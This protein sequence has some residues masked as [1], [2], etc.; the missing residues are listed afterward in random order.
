MMA[1]KMKTVTTDVV[2]L[3]GAE[4][5][6]RGLGAAVA[7]TVTGAATASTTGRL[8]PEAA[9]VPDLIVFVVVV[10]LAAVMDPAEAVAAV[11]LAAEATDANVALIPTRRAAAQVELMEHPVK[12]T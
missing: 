1:A 4:A 2:V 9:V 12:H 10:R 7:I 6:S 8:T 5:V 11:A 3:A